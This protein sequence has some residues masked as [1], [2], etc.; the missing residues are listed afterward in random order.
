M[1]MNNREHVP[2]TSIFNILYLVSCIRRYLIHCWC[3]GLE[4]FNSLHQDIGYRS[5]YALSVRSDDRHSPFEI[6]R[7]KHSSAGWPHLTLAGATYFTHNQIAGGAYF[8]HRDAVTC[9]F[10]T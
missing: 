2:A 9:V 5:A 6:F 3:C 1:H 10:G 7:E 4:D 8:A